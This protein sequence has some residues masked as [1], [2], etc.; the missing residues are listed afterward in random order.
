MIGIIIL[1]YINWEDTIRCIESIFVNEKKTLYHIY[2]VDNASPNRMNRD[3]ENFLLVQNRITFIQR[4]TNDGY[5]A[6]NN[7]GIK[8]ALSDGCQEILIVNNDVLLKNN[9]IYNLQEFL[10]LNK[11]VGIV[12]PKI[13]LAN[14]QLQMINMGIKTGLKEKYMYL[15]RKT[16]FSSF[17]K[18]FIRKF[19]ALDQDLTKPFEVHSVS[20]C[21]FMMSE[22]CAHDI[23]PFDEE[24]FLYQEELIIGIK[25]EE[26]GYKTVYYPSSE[27]T[28]VHGQSTK[29]IKAFSYICLVESEI[30]YF[31]KYLKTSKTALF[32]LYIIRTAKYI[33]LCLIHQNFR[34]N[35][36]LYFQSTL[37]KMFRNY[38]I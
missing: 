28:H 22:K 25:M 31:R 20:G 5:S 13:F 6:G 29:H 32:P 10:K 18:N 36:K 8:M 14:G 38:S 1:N 23:T 37:K 24:T 30:Y 27:V 21:C 4:E 7:S 34:T 15:L 3:V 17:V 12:G 33:T 11:E 35:I 9:S 26:K 16:I 19:C 2:V